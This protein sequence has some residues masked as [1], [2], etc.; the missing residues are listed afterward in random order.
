MRRSRSSVVRRSRA[1]TAVKRPRSMRA[2][3]CNAW[4]KRACRSPAGSRSRSC[5][6]TRGR[7]ATTSSRTTTAGRVST[8]SRGLRRLRSRPIRRRGG[9]RSRCPRS[10]TALEPGALAAA[11]TLA[12]ALL[13]LGAF[14]L[15]VREV[16]RRRRMLLE[17]ARFRSALARAL[18]LA[19]ASA[20]R[21]PDDRRRALA[22][23]ARVLAFDPNGGR[24]LAPAA[25]R[26]AWGRSE[27]S[28][29][30]LESLVDEIERTV[31]TR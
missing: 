9:N 19:R 3:P 13:V 11:L 10:R 18:E 2:T 5:S 6:C 30:G 7:A 23:L 16:T 27:P 31:E 1:Q 29:T 28:T 12:A 25:A 17:R 4:S 15:V 21:G 24:R 8:S 14:A 20:T 26:L 22:L